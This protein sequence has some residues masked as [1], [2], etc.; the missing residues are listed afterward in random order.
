[1]QAVVGLGLWIIGGRVEG[2]LDEVCL[3]VLLKIVADIQE[4]VNVKFLTAVF[5]SLILAAATQGEQ[6][7]FRLC[8][9][10]AS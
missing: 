6:L 10:L 2:W 8:R 1:M 9:P 4:P 3:F 5:G 7:S